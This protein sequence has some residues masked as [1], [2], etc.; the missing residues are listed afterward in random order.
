M[1][2]TSA[3]RPETGALPY[4]TTPVFDETSLPAA[5]RGRHSTKAGVWG[6]VRVLEGRVKLTY[7]DPEAELLLDPATPG[8]LLPQQPHYVE[9]LGPMRMCA[10]FYD[11]APG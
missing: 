9:P 10:E 6:M 5:L 11:R 7:L 1:R 2:T 4:R 3:S 8:P